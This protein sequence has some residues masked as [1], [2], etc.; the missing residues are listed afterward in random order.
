MNFQRCTIPPNNQGIT[1]VMII[2]V[3]HSLDVVVFEEP[4]DTT[5]QAHTHR[6]P[7]PGN[8]ISQ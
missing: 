1:D 4:E 5:G 6:H 3:I 2:S 7:Q 8:L